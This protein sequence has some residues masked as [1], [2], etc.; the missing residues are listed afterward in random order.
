MS[1]PLLTLRPYPSPSDSEEPVAIT[2]EVVGLPPGDEA[3]ISSIPPHEWRIFRIQTGRTV[4]WYG[5]Y[6][7]AEAALASLQGERDAE[8]RRRESD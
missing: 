6:P 7:T 2:Y 4:G 3:R 8:H 1:A 5:N